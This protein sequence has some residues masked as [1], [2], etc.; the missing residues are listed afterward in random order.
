V[1]DVYNTNYTYPT[2]AEIDY[3]ASKGLG[4]IRLPFLWER[5]QLRHHSGKIPVQDAVARRQERV[6]VVSL[7]DAVAALD[8]P[9]QQV[10]VDDRHL[11][12]V[13]GESASRAESG[14][15]GPEHNGS[16]PRHGQPHSVTVRGMT[17]LNVVPSPG[18]D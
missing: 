7:R 3:Y 1:P 13:V 2:D 18:A 9:G 6:Q 11:R 8:L 12:E 14:H 4:V 17:S 5:L 10:A 15:A 16:T